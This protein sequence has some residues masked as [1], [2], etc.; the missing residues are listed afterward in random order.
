MQLRWKMR[1]KLRPTTQRDARRAHRLGHVLAR[2]PRAEVL[3]DH[4]HRVAHQAVAERGV[5]ALE[6]VRA[7]PLGVL[8]VE[9][10]PGVEDVGVDVVLGDHDRCALDDHAGAPARPPRPDRR[11]R[12]PRRRP[13]R[14]GRS[15]GTPASPCRPCA[16]GSCGSSSPPPSRPRPG[17]P[18]RRRSTR[19][20]SASRPSRRPRRT[21]RAAPRP[22]PR[23]RSLRLAGTMITRTSGCTCARAACRPP[24][25]GRSSCRS[26][27]CRR[28][29]G[30]RACRATSASGSTL[31][32]EC[33]RG[34]QRRQG[35]EVDAQRAGD[36]ARRG[37]TAPRSTAVGR[38]LEVRRLVVVG[39]ED[40]RSPSPP[41]RPCWP[42][43]AA[44][45]RE[46]LGAVADELQHLP[47]AAVHADLREHRQDQVLAGHPAALAAA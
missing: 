29:P 15:P 4:Q 23:A 7:H 22:A 18:C 25:A 13:P 37:R 42:R 16:R 30:R 10:R 26:S 35:V 38:A 21:R 20:T 28:R 46:R 40:A 44:R 31:P 41:R 33:G 34:H 8:E 24:G 17:C 12:P 45:R 27:S 32:G 39:G 19:R 11:A 14:R 6:E 36:L 3:A 43:P 5:E 47:G 2:R 1:A 9:E